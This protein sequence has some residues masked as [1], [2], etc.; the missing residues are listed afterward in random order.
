MTMF[1]G[2]WLSGRIFTSYP[3]GRTPH[4]MARAHLSLSLIE[5][6]KRKG[7]SQSDIA[8]LYGTSRQAV[9]WHK[10][11]YGGTLTP[12]EQ[13]RRHFPWQVPAEMNQASPCRRL[14][15]HGEYMVTGGVGM[16]QDKLRRLRTF[17]RQLREEQQVVE[18]DPSIPPH[19]GVAHTGGFALRPRSEED[20]DLLIR[21]NEHTQLSPEG[22]DI[23]K[24]PPVDPQ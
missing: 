5:D 23:W 22:R 6:L 16:S 14:R 21:V 8:R 19:P 7:M 13:A 15:D 20:L 11:T 9:S 17:Y 3:D 4:R 10:V 2:V 24:F 18:F 12:R 1:R